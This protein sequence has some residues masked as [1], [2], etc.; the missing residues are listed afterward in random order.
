MIKTFLCQ[1]DDDIPVKPPKKLSQV[2]FR[3]CPTG[4][5]KYL[6]LRKKYVEV[7][8]FQKLD[9][10]PQ[11]RVFTEKSPKWPTKDQ[12]HVRTIALSTN[13]QG[14]RWSKDSSYRLLKPDNP[15][16]FQGLYIYIY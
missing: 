5:Q 4:M 12:E 9:T 6:Q 13:P 14:C 10:K 2:S 16:I 1:Y 15:V 3:T 11:G 7:N 8:H